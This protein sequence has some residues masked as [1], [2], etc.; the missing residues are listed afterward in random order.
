MAAMTCLRCGRSGMV[1]AKE[2]GAAAPALEWSD[3]HAG[4][5][6]RLCEFCGSCGDVHE[7]WCGDET[8]SGTDAALDL[9]DDALVHQRRRHEQQ[10]CSCGD[11]DDRELPDPACVLVAVVERQRTMLSDMARQVEALHLDAT[12]ARIGV[13]VLDERLHGGG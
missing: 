12:A 13:E 5:V 11:H 8:P 3:E 10:E 2:G 6:C 4:Y 1:T 9:A 7:I